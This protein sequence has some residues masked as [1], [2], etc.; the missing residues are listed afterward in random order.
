MLL[1]VCHFGSYFYLSGWNEP[2]FLSYPER[3]DSSEEPNAYERV[4]KDF[5]PST[6]AA[7]VGGIAYF[8]IAIL[9]SWFMVRNRS[10]WS[11]C[12]P[13]GAIGML[14]NMIPKLRSRLTNTKH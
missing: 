7:L 11:W 3:D 2:I 12:L 5:E 13:V 6:A 10:W 8:M 1:K 4:F 9:H 14:T